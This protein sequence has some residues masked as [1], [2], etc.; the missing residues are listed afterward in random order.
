MLERIQ[1]LLYDS[2]KHLE[3]EW[4][5]CSKVWH[6]NLVSQYHVVG[7]SPE[8]SNP[9]FQGT[10]A[11]QRQEAAASVSGV[12]LSVTGSLYQHIIL[13]GKMISQHDN[14]LRCR[15]VKLSESGFEMA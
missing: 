3:A 7:L 15:S 12:G 5:I 11:G 1:G 10:A 14:T 6:T 13:R 4:N 8:N 2:F 9:D